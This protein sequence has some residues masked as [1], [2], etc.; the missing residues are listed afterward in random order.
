MVNFGNKFSNRAWELV[1]TLILL[2]VVGGMTILGTAGSTVIY[3]IQVA[4]QDWGELLALGFAVGMTMVF[5]QL[6]D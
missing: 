6:G 4:L 1:F 3:A 2:A 5:M